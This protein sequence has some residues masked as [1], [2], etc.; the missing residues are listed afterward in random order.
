MTKNEKII[1]AKTF[2][3]KWH[4]QPL[5]FYVEISGHVGYVMHAKS[6]NEKLEVGPKRNKPFVDYPWSDNHCKL[7]K[8]LEEAIT[9]QLQPRVQLYGSL[10]F[11]E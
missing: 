7:Q 2:G 8:E 10:V 11:Q 6:W 9:E 4:R 3:I 5:P 1:K